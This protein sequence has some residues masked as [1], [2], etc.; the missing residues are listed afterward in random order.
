MLQRTVPEGKPVR[1]P[2]LKEFIG[3]IYVTRL[4]LFPEGRKSPEH[5][6]PRGVAAQD[7][8]TQ[9]RQNLIDMDRELEVAERKLG[10]KR[11]GV[12]PVL[13]PLT[14]K[15]WRSFHLVHGR[16]HLKQIEALRQWL[17]SDARRVA[18]NA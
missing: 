18:S 15:G 2:T 14:A 9:I 13:G 6:E 7:V 10:R 17:S 16:H 1:R 5:A 12:H 8:V 3:A 11:I 4:G